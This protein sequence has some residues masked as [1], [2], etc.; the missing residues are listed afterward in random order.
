[1]I[2]QGSKELHITKL[3]AGFMISVML[4]GIFSLS[5]VIASLFTNVTIRSSGTI[6]SILPLHVEGRYIKNSLNQTVILRGVNKVEFADDPD[7]TWMGSTMW[8]DENVAAEVDAMKSWSI[9]VVRCHMSVELWKYDAG[10]NSGNPASPYCAIS[11]REAIKRLLTM[12]A[13][14]GIY[15]LLDGYSIGS[16]WD[17]GDQ[18]PLP[19]PPYQKST[20][21]SEVIGSVDDYVE[22]MKS[23]ANELKRYPNAII[24]LWN[25]PDYN[26]K[27]PAYTDWLNASQRAI[28]A[29]RETGAENLI[30]FQWTTGVYCNLPDVNVESGGYALRDWLER[31]ITALSDP[32]GNLVFST[33]IYRSGGG[34]GL[35]TTTAMQEKWGSQYAWDYDEIKRAFLYMGLKWAGEELNVPLII[36]EIGGNLGW[37]TSNPTEH[38]HEMIGFNNTLTIL[39][40]WNMGYIGFWWRNVDVYRLL[41]NG[42]PWV[43]PPTQSGHI[44]IDAIKSGK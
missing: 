7:G 3:Y 26:P 38:Q 11:A 17:G 39:N 22:W 25:E 23:V 19:F 40:E 37:E 24:E 30:V 42:L 9:N 5:P 12:A 10:P 6:A 44:L 32:L 21:A 33:H 43:P 1:M 13:E 18:D 20:N 15:V 29:I 34:T 36:G 41:Q 27:E 14:K 28:T 35:Y 31:A 2:K 4:A 8:K 16:Y